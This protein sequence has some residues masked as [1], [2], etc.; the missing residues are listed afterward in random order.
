MLLDKFRSSDISRL[1]WHITNVA[2]SF[3]SASLC[4]MYFVRIVSPLLNVQLKTAFAKTAP[5]TLKSNLI[6]G[7]KLSEWPATLWSLLIEYAQLHFSGALH[8]RRLCL[9][10]LVHG[11]LGMA[12][13]TVQYLML[14]Q[15][16]LMGKVNTHCTYRQQPAVMMTV[17]RCFY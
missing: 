10:L 1:W 11:V 17:C 9:Q 15:S 14:L 5:T 3:C 16:K 8:T 7:Q 6:S 4:N 12:S 13:T 2:K